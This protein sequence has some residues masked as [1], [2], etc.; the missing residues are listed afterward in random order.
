[1]TLSSRAN[2]VLIPSQAVQGGQKGQYVYVV[3][4]G[5]S[6]EMRL[7]SVFRTIDQESIIDHGVAAGERVVTDGQLRLTPKSKVD[8]KGRA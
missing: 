5:G 2:A 7:V 6:V 3:K 8:I 4:D 1:M